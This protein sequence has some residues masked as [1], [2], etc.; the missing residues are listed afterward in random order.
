MGSRDTARKAREA[1]EGRTPKLLW[2]MSQTTETTEGRL[3]PESRSAGSPSPSLNSVFSEGRSPFYLVETRDPCT[4]EQ[5]LRMESLR[6]PC[7]H[8]KRDGGTPSD[9]TRELESRAKDGTF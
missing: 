7:W 4:T 6:A 8:T 9:T 2:A 1:T 3:R 5:A